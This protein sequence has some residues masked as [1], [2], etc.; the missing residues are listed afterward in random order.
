M[1]WNETEIV[2]LKRLR[3]VDQCFSRVCVSRFDEARFAYTKQV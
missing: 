1:E 3:N 2:K